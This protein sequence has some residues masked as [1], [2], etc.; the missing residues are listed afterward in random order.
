MN[1]L[2]EATASE[3]TKSPSGNYN[4]VTIRAKDLK[5]SIIVNE[6]I[7]NHKIEEDDKP[8]FYAC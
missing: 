8:T 5:L 2:H 7:Y 6:A 4:I 1:G 3:P